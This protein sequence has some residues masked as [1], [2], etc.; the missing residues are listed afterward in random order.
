M[1]QQP[2]PNSMQE[3]RD[4]Q[5]RVANYIAQYEVMTRD[6]EAVR[7]RGAFLDGILAER[8]PDAAPADPGLVALPDAEEP[9]PTAEAAAE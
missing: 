5:T 8:P 7:Q 4:E 6:I 1:A 9:E 2:M 3:A